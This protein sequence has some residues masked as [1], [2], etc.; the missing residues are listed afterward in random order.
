[1]KFL[2]IM[3]ILLIT[4]ACTSIALVAQADPV[5]IK[6][7]TV[8]STREGVF[9]HSMLRAQQHMARQVK[10]HTNG[11]VILDVLDGGR[12]D[13]SPREMAAMVAEG[14]VIQAANLNAFFFP[15]V[16]ELFVQ[17]I[18]FLFTGDEHARRFPASEP[19]RWMAEKVESAYDVKMLGYLLVASHVAI[20]GVEPVRD[21]SDFSGKILNGSRGMDSMFE[22]VKPLRIEH[23]GFGAAAR[24]ELANSD[25]DITVGLMQNNYT[26]QLYKRFKHTTLVHN[27]YNIYYTPILNKDV[28]N[29][30][31]DS[32]RQGINLAMR[33]TEN[34]SVSYQHDSTI[35]AY[36]LAQSLGVEMHMQTDAERQEWKAEFYP[37]IKDLA[38]SKSSDPEETLA[39]IKAIEDLRSDQ[40]WR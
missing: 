38:V 22:N 11:E 15:K 19:A 39:M 29:S 9:P 10:E 28:W 35:W 27:Y 40:K 1:M 37:I 20:S 16:P 6:M 2:K 13:L 26:Q 12:Q 24:G 25:I 14:D 36:Q 3:T 21:L 17:S 4:S 30:L 23:V 32:Q 33:D 7:G 34:A 8:I 18:P 5:V 31:S